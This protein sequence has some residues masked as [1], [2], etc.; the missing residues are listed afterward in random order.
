MT[1]HRGDQSS[2]VCL[3]AADVVVLHDFQPFIEDRTF[4]VPEALLLQDPP[5]PGTLQTKAKVKMPAREL[6]GLDIVTDATGKHTGFAVTG[7][8]LY[9]VDIASGQ[10]VKLGNVGKGEG[11]LIDVAVIAAK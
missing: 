8:K 5:N 7:A 2:V 9:R 3:L 10:I 11:Q 6:R 1:L 4:I